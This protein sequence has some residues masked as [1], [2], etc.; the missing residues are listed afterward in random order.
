MWGGGTEAL[1]E[2]LRA[3]NNEI[4]VGGIFCDLKKAFDCVHHDVLL[5]KLKFYGVGGKANALME[6]YL[7]DR[8]QRVVTN[9]RYAHSNWGK[10]VNGIPQGSI[11]GL[12]LFLLYINDLPHIIKSK[13]I[14]II[15]A[16]DS[17]IIVKN[18]NRIEYENELTLIL[19]TINEW[20]KANLLT[21]MLF[22][23]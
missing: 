15:F 9:K 8:H 11:L 23:L 10:V 13:S 3:L 1:D 6:S 20:F 18:S 5:S 14:P 19:K 7:H 16:D 12:L 4:P 2:I 21:L 22:P 17:S